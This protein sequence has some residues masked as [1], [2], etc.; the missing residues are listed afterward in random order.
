[1]KA[2]SW[3]IFTA[4]LATAGCGKADEAMCEKVIAKIVKM[5]MGDSPRAQS[6]LEGD[7]QAKMMEACVGKL[8][9]REA[10]CVLAAEDKTAYDLCK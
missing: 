7:K 2:R 4:L 3:L 6:V 9:S 5:E 1:M 8:S 10:D